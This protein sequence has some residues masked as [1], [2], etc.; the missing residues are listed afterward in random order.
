MAEVSKTN[1]PKNNNVFPDC[2]IELPPIKNSVH[3]TTALPSF[4]RHA[5]ISD[6]RHD[7]LSRYDWMKLN[8]KFFQCEMWNRLQAI[9]RRK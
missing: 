5:D 2:R 8:K 9:N 7:I 1:T 6:K 4:I 3:S